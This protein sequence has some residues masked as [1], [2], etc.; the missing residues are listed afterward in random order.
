[1]TDENSEVETTDQPVEDTTDN[2]D[3]SNESVDASD[4]QEA[5]ETARDNG[6]DVEEFERTQAAL[7]KVNKE[8][9]ARRIELQK[10]KELGVDTDTVKQLLKEQ[11]EAEIKKAEEEGKYQEVLDRMQRETQEK[12]EAAEGKVAQMQQGLE[13]QLKDKAIIEAIAAEDGIVKLLK[14]HVGQYVKLVETDEG[15]YVQKV[16]DEDGQPMLDKKGK[17]LNLRGLLK[18][19]KTDPDLSYAFKAPR[20][21]GSGTNNSESPSS[22][23]PVNSNLRRSQMSE[24][25]QRSF[26]R[27]HGVKEY[28]KLKW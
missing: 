19:L 21:S 18:V 23:N 24:K 3:V 15:E 4:D 5:L 2:T 22:G 26:V 7:A 25:D 16:V 8:S 6:V 17:P 1:M 12:I 11:R 9:A 20:T 13:R 27:E 14:S 10:W 28:R